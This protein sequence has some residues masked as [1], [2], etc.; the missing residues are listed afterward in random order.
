MTAATARAGNTCDIA[1]A[2]GIAIDAAVSALHA[3]LFS[4]QSWRDRHAI[5]NAIKV[6]RRLRR[7][8]LEI[9]A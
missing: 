9:V 7:P 5:N 6:V 1:A 8:Q 2:R 3:A 4:T